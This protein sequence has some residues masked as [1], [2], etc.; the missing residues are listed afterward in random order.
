MTRVVYA[1]AASVGSYG[2]TDIEKGLTG[3]VPDAPD[4]YR[5]PSKLSAGKSPC[6]PYVYKV[7]DLPFDSRSPQ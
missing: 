7:K 4:I 6:H 3:N 2:V 1:K 5:K